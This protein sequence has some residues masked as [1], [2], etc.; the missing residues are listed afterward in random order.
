MSLRQEVKDGSSLR[1]SI[2]SYG[3]FDRFQM[4]GFTADGAFLSH[5]RLLRIKYS[6]I[7]DI[8]RGGVGFGG[9]NISAELS[10][11]AGE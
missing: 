8:T 9:V 3:R 10:P 2:H 4:C 5:C 11:I 6:L 7:R 1:R